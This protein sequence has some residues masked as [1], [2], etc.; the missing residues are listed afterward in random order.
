V[1]SADI[2]DERNPP[3]PPT[4]PE[5]WVGGGGGGGGGCECN[6]PGVNFDLGCD[7]CSL[8]LIKGVSDEVSVWMFRMKT[9]RQ[10]G[11]ITVN[12][13]GRVHGFPI[14]A[15]AICGYYIDVGI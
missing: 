10:T 13:G 3:R 6:D 15:W 8:L 7:V 12:A 9:E 14:R 1:I 5:L 11:D 4:N 2:R